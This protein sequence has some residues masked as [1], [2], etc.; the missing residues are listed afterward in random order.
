MESACPKCSR[1]LPEVETLKYRFC[2]YCGTEIQ[3]RLK[4]LDDAFLTLPPD[5]PSGP[6][7]KIHQSLSPQAPQKEPFGEQFN[8]QAI[9]PWA[10]S[11]RSHLKMKPPN[12]PPPPG[13]F[14]ISSEKKAPFPADIKKQQP[15]LKR[16]K[17]VV[18]AAL[19]LLAVIILIVG[20]FFTF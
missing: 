16:R 7:R 15:L 14:R 19:V 8:D 10:M 9:E 18:I 1:Q 13:F 12:T 6:H 20:W 11:K 4:D 3:A 17:N 5:L 2:P